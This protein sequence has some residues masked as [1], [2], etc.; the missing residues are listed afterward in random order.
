MQSS[1]LAK[2]I[3]LIDVSIIDLIILYWK[4]S[5]SVNLQEKFN[6]NT[7]MVCTYVNMHADP[8]W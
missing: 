7:A 1:L 6:K 2:W 4:N 5:I 3:I 8:E